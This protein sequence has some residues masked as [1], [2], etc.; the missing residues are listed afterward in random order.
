MPLPSRQRSF[1]TSPSRAASGLLA[2]AFL[3][4][5]VAAE[6]SAYPTKP[7][8]LIVP[9]PAG[10][11]SDTI[12]RIVAEKVAKEWGQPIVID[13]RTGGNTVIGG[14]AA[15]MSPADG[16]TVLQ[17]SSNALIVSTIQEKLPYDLQKDFRPVIG[18]GAVPLL[19]AVPA[20]SSTR[21][22][23][24]L[25][26]A[27]K[28]QPGGLSYA[29]GGVGSLGHLAP[30]RFASE[31]KIPATHIPYRGVAPALQDVVG[32]RVQLM[33]VTTP[34]GVPMA[35]GGGIRVLG[36]TSEER[37]ASLPDV[38]TMKELGMANFTPAV[39]YGFVVPAKT[40]DAAVTR[41]HDVIAKVV[42]EPTVQARLAELGLAVK[43]TNGRE[44]GKFMGEEWVRWRKIVK[45]N[46]IKME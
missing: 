42:A 18:I 5:T 29:S 26:A 25:V 7:V 44:F 30:F 17:V 33:F 21:S 4:G 40:P 43:V 10:G 14:Q 37:I 36:V 20:S 32:N 6:T 28:A 2:A 23:A 11:S 39:W 9:F 15:A 35:K 22:I 3:V 13:N 41:L 12:S 16:Y 38:P 24:D 27:A 45:D 1:L 31:L 19:L 8:K 34:E 46:D